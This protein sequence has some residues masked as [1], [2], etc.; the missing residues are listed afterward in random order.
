M[1]ESDPVMGAIS[2]VIRPRG[3]TMKPMMGMT[4]MFDAIVTVETLLK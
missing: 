3:R 1:M 4:T 2:I